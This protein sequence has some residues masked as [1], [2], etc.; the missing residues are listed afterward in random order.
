MELKFYGGVN[1][2]GGNKILI[3]DNGT[4]VF[5]D[6]GKNFQREREFFDN[7]SL[8]PFYIYDLIK[9]GVIPPLRG[10]YKNDSLPKPSIDA[11]LVTHAHLDHCGYLSL[12]RNDIPIYIGETTIKLMK[13]REEMS[14]QA[15]WLKSTE[16]LNNSFR[17]FRTKL[18]E[19]IPI[20]GNIS[21][22]PIHVDH[23][24]PASYSF[25]VYVGSKTIAY[26][27]DLR[28]HGYKKELTADF[29]KK[30]E[31]EK[32]DIMICSATK[33]E[34]EM[35]ESKL[36]RSEDEVRKEL[37]EE[38][39]YADGLVMVETSSADIDRIR[40][41]WQVA[42]KTGRN[43]VLTTNQAYLLYKL[44][45]IDNTISELPTP[46]DS[47]TYLRRYRE[48][49][50]HRTEENGE[51]YMMGRPYWQQDL[52]SMVESHDKDHLLWGEKGREVIRKNPSAYIFCTN[53]AAHELM[54]LKPVDT[55][56]PCKFILSRS[57]P[58]DEESEID[59][60]R[61]MNWL[62]LFG[63]KDYKQI[64]A[65]GHMYS[66]ELKEMIERANPDVIYP[67]HTK[68]PKMLKEICPKANVIISKNNM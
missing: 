30:L 19:P 61:L 58:F 66:N 28:A 40:T 15:L 24:I 8:R 27:G 10:L 67:I 17:L 14:I 62:K 25:I 20:K 11:I 63:I 64:H 49:Y 32:I 38:V 36:L 42:Q 50:I 26:T 47:Y 44:Q 21:F 41:I 9:S 56:F 57:E 60:K 31:D 54:E 3:E 34:P 4:R 39:K 46:C 16:H 23:S 37:T 33:V 18:N 13:I 53:N 52:I 35:K 22:L 51:A 7:I 48:P 45:T 55:T 43:F 6:F 5:L 59:F 29:I 2:I 65:S 12:V 68:H 1:E